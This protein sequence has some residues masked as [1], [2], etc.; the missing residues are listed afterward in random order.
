MRIKKYLNLNIDVHK[1][2]NCEN[3]VGQLSKV[4]QIIIEKILI[5]IQEKCTVDDFWFRC[6]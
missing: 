1:G 4:A 3:E 2:K 5:A 6:K